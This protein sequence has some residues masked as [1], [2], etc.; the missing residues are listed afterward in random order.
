MR[1][2][3]KVWLVLFI[4]VFYPGAAVSEEPCLAFCLR[5]MRDPETA[6]AVSA[7]LFHHFPTFRSYEQEFQLFDKKIKEKERLS[8]IDITFQSIHNRDI[9]D[10]DIRLFC[11]LASGVSI[12]LDSWLHGD[13]K[14]ISKN[15]TI[16]NVIAFL[17]R[18][19]FE[20]E[21]YSLCDQILCLKALCSVE[22]MIHINRDKLVYLKSKFLINTI[23]SVRYKRE[24]FN[25]T[26][27]GHNVDYFEFSL[28]SNQDI[29]GILP[30]VSQK[31]NNFLQI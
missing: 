13:Y 14:V 27:N 11:I 29:D 2:V 15:R 19:F 21:F 30:K 28:Y 8:K 25:I 31:L 20:I 12:V 17:N 18:N 5:A 22:S 1:C 16:G 10:P 9:K 23:A 6:A 7:E 3:V 26:F 4:C 24:L